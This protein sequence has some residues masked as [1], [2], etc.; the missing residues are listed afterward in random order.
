MISEIL[1]LYFQAIAQIGKLKAK[2]PPGIGEANPIARH[3]KRNSFTGDGKL[4]ISF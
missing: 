4:S 3:H 1:F 2:L